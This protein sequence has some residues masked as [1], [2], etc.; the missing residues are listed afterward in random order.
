MK[1]RSLFEA[2]RL[3]EILDSVPHKTWMVRPDG[4]ALYYNRATREYVGQSLDPD[5]ANRDRLLVHP[6]DL[7][8]LSEARNRA[9]ADAQDFAVELR[10]RRSDGAWR[11]HRLNVSVLSSGGKADAWVVTATDFDDLRRALSAAE[12]AGND[13][14]LA[15]EAA[16]LGIYSFDLETR[17]HTWSPELKRIFGLRADAQTPQEILPLIHPED[18]DRVGTVIQASLDPGG[19]GI[20]EDE[21][22]IVR[23]DGDIRWVFAKGKMSFEGEGGA[24]KAR[25]GLGFVQDITERKT[26]ETALAQSEERYRTLVESATDI[27]TTLELDGR[28]ATINPA[29]ERILGYT[30]EELV[31]ANIARFVPPDQMPMQREVLQRKL[32]GETTTQYELEVLPKGR[33]DRRVLDVRSRL[34]FDHAGKPV[35]IHSIARDITERKEAEAR[36]TVLVRE[37]QHRTRN[38]LAVIQSIATTTLRRSKSLDGALEI[39][40]GRLHALA[41]AQEF[42]ASGP[43]GG[44]PLRQLV[45]G[46]LAP[47]AARTIVSG[48]PLVVGGAFAQSFALLLHELATNAVKHGALA[49]P[50]GRVVI[51]WRVEGSDPGPR[52]HFSWQERGGPPARAPTESGLGTVLMASLGESLAEFKDEGFE[53]A[54]A[55]PLAEAVRGSDVQ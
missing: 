37:L 19:D 25:W 22:R 13:L 43:G 54:V 23:P 4:T 3:H 52:L 9:I 6:E 29:A 36:Q 28:I 38:M 42:V 46:E 20:F 35:A 15:A 11:W 48:E 32:D 49:A 47:F 50:N 17:E 10:L 26:A 44:V 8:R 40:I 12:Q 45:D 31:G 5:R 30:R 34:V 51:G 55:V 7:P 39:L 14:R 33:G 21:H 27:I 1:E 2:A 24:R 18:R 53:Y 41:N 16:R